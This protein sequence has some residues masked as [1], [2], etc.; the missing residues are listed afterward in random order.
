MP[1]LPDVE[2]FRR[3]LDRTCQG[4]VI[5]HVVVSDPRLLSGL[6]SGAFAA[7]LEGAR[8][9]GSQRHS[10]HLL[11]RL[12]PAGWLTMHFGMTGALHHWEGAE[13]EPP[14]TRIRCDFADGHHLAYTNL[15]RLGAV[16]L[17]DDAESF[18]ATER[19]GLDALDP[20]FDFDAF[21]R[22]LS[23][24][25]RDIK[26]LL[27][28]Q[29]VIAGIGNIYSDEI[30]FQAGIHPKTTTDRLSPDARELLFRQTKH[31]LQTAIKRGSGA[32]L[33]PDALPP[34]FLLPHR[35]RGGHCQRCG[36][37]W[38]RRSFP[39]GP[40]ITVRTARLRRSDLPPFILRSYSA[41]VLPIARIWFWVL[42][43]IKA[44]DASCRA[45][46]PQQTRG[47]SMSEIGGLLEPQLPVLRRYARALTRDAGCADDPVQ[48]CLVR[49][50]ANQ[51]RWREGTDLRAWLC[52]ILHNL[53]INDLRCR[54]RERDRLK[55]VNVQ[56]A[57]R[58]RQFRDRPSP[59]DPERSARG[60][61]DRAA[62][63]DLRPGRLRQ[64]CAIAPHRGRAG[65]PEGRRRQIACR[66]QGAHDAGDLDRRPVLA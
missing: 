3:Y 26:S 54:A 36:A 11:V 53:F 8:I 66:R 9:M 13:P 19:L 17:V 5:R 31:V 50:L 63:G 58:R 28:D 56:L 41:V 33:N 20:Q 52:T 12:A 46:T 35:T 60:G 22:A 7:R 59:A 44:G 32:E 24:R 43:W 2:V 61:H 39:G 29:T 14:Y 47:I 48:N 42:T 51:H 45:N 15:R 16:G 10:K 65:A 25:K 21:E 38:A 37:S 40:P 64:D 49:A 30:L 6:A 34:S 57:L 27:M 62:R 23:A 55:T 18:I 1:E 4:R